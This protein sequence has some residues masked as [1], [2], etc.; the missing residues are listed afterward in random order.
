MPKVLEPWGRLGPRVALRETPD[1]L[2]GT[3]RGEGF[4]EPMTGEK[5]SVVEECLLSPV[6]Q[7]P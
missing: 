3:G 5:V 4:P 7:W 2:A 6:N 1:G